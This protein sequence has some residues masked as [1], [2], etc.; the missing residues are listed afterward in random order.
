MKNRKR[1]IRTSGSVRDEDG[2][3]PHLLGRRQFLRVAAG[4]AANVS[5]FALAQ[6]D[7]PIKIGFSTPMT[8]GLAANGKSGLLAQK[9]WEED[10]NATG[11]L[12]GRSVTL[13]FNSFCVRG[14]RHIRG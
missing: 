6:S 8:G 2:Q 10:V 14:L 3:H 5:Q 12:L 1:E 11:G 13:V 4:A 7:R 9:I